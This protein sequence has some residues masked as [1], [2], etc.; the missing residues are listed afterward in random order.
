[1]RRAP[2]IAALVLGAAL[3]LSGC[4][5]PS[6]G[7]DL[8][9]HVVTAAESVAAGD[10]DGAAAAI[11]ELEARVLSARDASG[12]S[13]EEADEI[14]AT[15]TLVRADLAALATP[16]APE[17]ETP[18]APVEEQQP[19]VIP[20]DQGDTPPADQGADSGEEKGNGG[21]PDDKGKG[22]DKGKGKHGDG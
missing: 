7:E 21:K 1:M 9:A 6:P 13:P 8:R 11:D 2:R 19:A 14:L 17:T 5:A 12:L 18:A 4:A 16:P 22:G 20:D 3:L 10:L 15:I